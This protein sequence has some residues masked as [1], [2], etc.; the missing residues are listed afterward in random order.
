[1]RKGGSEGEER[2]DCLG[3]AHLEFGVSQDRPNVD[4]DQARWH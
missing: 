3:T 1:M 2:G 4:I